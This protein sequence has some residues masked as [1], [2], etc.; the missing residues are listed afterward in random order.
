MNW[1]GLPNIKRLHI[2]RNALKNPVVIIALIFTGLFL[3][4]ENAWAQQKVFKGNDF[5]YEELVLHIE[6][7]YVLAPGVYSPSQA[8]YTVQGNR[9]YYGQASFTDNPTYTVRDDKLYKDNAL[10]STDIL[11][12]F[13]DGR[14]YKGNSTFLMDLLYTIKDGAIYK[15]ETTYGPECIVYLNGNFSTADLYAVM[16]SLNLL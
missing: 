14:I 9:L 7:G 12:T 10:Y 5:Y 2:N 13:K 1:V 16:L 8:L 6:N 3:Q 11:Y 4:S 15:G